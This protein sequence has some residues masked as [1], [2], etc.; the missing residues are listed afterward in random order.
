MKGSKNAAF[1]LKDVAGF[2]K[3]QP[4]QPIEHIYDALVSSTSVNVSVNN[5][6]VMCIQRKVPFHQEKQKASPAGPVVAKACSLLP[7]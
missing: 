2:K 4:F 5:A 6:A 3:M 7:S 1:P